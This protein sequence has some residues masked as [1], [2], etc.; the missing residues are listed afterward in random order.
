M[1]LATLPAVKSCFM[2]RQGTV[3]ERA[4]IHLNNGKNYSRTNINIDYLEV[5]SALIEEC[6]HSHDEQIQPQF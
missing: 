5:D 6:K 4:T 3:N 1:R 2:E